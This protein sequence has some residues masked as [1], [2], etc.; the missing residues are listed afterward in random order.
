MKVIGFVIFW[1]IG[2]VVALLGNKRLHEYKDYEY[3]KFMLISGIFLSIFMS[4][5]LVVLLFFSW[6][7][8]LPDKIYHSCYNNSYI[9]SY[10]E[11]YLDENNNVVGPKDN[12]K[13][14]ETYRV[15]TCKKCGKTWKE[16]LQ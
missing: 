16:R 14:H 12:W 2:I 8:K 9:S 10:E 3:P 13:K 6:E 7:F 15:Y 4:W 11:V 1:L 5:V